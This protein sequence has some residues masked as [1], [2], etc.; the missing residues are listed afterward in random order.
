MRRVPWPLTRYRLP[1]RAADD[2]YRNTA[3]FL[4]ARLRIG[5]AEARRRLALAEGLLPRQ[6]FAGRPGAARAPGARRRGRGR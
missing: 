1:R 2:G 3:E 5:A 4:R 6:G